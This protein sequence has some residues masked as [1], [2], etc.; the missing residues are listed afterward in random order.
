MSST[1]A[2]AMAS[3][4]HSK[5]LSP[6]RDGGDIRACAGGIALVCSTVIDDMF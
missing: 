3:V 5:A 2:N 1:T 6:T 4:S